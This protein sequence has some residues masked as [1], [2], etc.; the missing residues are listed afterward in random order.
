MPLVTVEKYLDQDEQ[1][2]HGDFKKTDL[3]R[4]V[5][6]AVVILAVLY[7][8]YTFAFNNYT[9]N[10]ISNIQGSLKYVYLLLP[11]IF[12]GALTF[13]IIHQT[14]NKIF[15]TNKGLIVTTMF[16]HQKMYFKEMQT[17]VVQSTEY[18]GGLK[19]LIKN[20]TS[21]RYYVHI[22]GNENNKQIIYN[23]GSGMTKQYAEI[24]KQT[25]IDEAARQSV[26]IS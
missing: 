6:P 15:V 8:V 24:L 22:Q 19:A 5:L 16:T 2:L 4:K 12:V 9:K 25:I 21:A 1:I 11:L 13:G 10:Y 26:K 23:G 14:K 17:V 20:I 7:L 18:F 3:L